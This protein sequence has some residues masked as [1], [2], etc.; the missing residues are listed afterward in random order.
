MTRT[1]RSREPK[2]RSKIS[3]TSTERWEWYRRALRKKTPSGGKDEAVGISRSLIGE[4]EKSS[5][6]RGDGVLWK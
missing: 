3:K 6:A 2:T 5:L 4:S 1:R